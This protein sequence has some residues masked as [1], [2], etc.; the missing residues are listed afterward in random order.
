[1]NRSHTAAP[2]RSSAPLDAQRLLGIYLNDHLAGSAGGVALIR[3]TAHAQRHT[4]AGPV[5]AEL[6]REIEQDQD[7]L[8]QMM[9]V[10]DIPERR[11]R[12]AVGRIMERIGRVKP[13][14]RLLARSPLSDLIELEAMRLGVTG[15]VS[16]WQSLRAVAETDRRLSTDDLDHLV[17]RAQRQ[18]DIL[19]D[20]SG[21]AAR[22]G[23]AGRTDAHAG[24]VPSTPR[25]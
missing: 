4:A 25:P 6:S 7:S 10:L 19:R 2:R 23:L 18:A 8:R 3:R 21:E 14:G 24:P 15:K 5:L 1:M 9:N 22:F 13:N 11:S 12:I 20:L 17:S 16:L